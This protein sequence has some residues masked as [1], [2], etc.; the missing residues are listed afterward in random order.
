MFKLHF[1]FSDQ[2][3]FVKNVSLKKNLGKWLEKTRSIT[4]FHLMISLFGK[5]LD[6]S[7]EERPESDVQQQTWD[8]HET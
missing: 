1:Y 4:A 2:D 5:P 3:V 7:K 6:F 8:N